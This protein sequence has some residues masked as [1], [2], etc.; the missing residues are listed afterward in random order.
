MVHP[1]AQ[2]DCFDLVDRL[3]AAVYSEAPWAGFLESAQH[4]LPNGQVVLFFHNRAEGRG[5]LSMS[6]GLDPAVVES[7][8]RVYSCINPWMDHAAARP[9]GK[10]MQADEMLPRDKL[11]RTQY[12]HEFLRPQ[13]LETGLGVTLRRRDATNFFFSI[14]SA[15]APT[16]TIEAARRTISAL[17]PHLDRVFDIH[18]AGLDASRTLP[19]RGIIRVTGDLKVVEADERALHLLDRMQIIS[20][21][22]RRQLKCHDPRLSD[23]VRALT[24]ARRD[25]SGAPGIQC[26]HLKRHDGAPPLRI[27]IYRP[28][29]AAE[30]F[31]GSDCILHLEDPLD[32]LPTA[33]AEYARMYRLSAAEAGIVLGLVHGH[34]LQKIAEARQSS[35]ATVRTQMKS[36][37]YKTDAKRQS[38]IVKHVCIMSASLPGTPDRGPG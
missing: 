31:A 28:G 18:Q 7:Y 34:S 20:I 5:A 29:A 2:P 33:V 14:I 12:Y 38:D 27:R 10:V 13:D 30:F 9:L 16:D 3:Y 19:G 6:A 1:A 4:L 11:H 23:C 35:I 32:M 37:F 36:I 15:D 25:G 26:L 24:E 22:P 8:N 21:G 17:A